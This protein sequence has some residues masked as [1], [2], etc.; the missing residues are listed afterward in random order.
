MNDIILYEDSDI[1]ICQ[2]PAGLSVQSARLGQMDLE[3][4][5]KNHLAERNPGRMPFVGVVHRLDQ[6]VEG[7][8]VFGKN[9]RATAALNR[10]LQ[11]GSLQKRYL[12]VLCGEPD[13][14]QGCLTDYL[15]KD[16]RSHT[17]AV[18]P[19][20]I[21]GGKKAVL[22]YCLLEE[23]EGLSLVEIELRTGRHHQ[24]RVQMAHRGWPLA[25][26][27]KYGNGEKTNTVALCAYKLS[28]RHPIS[29]KRM[30]FQVSPGGEIFQRFSKIL[31][32]YE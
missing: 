16:G 11:D 13:P 28:L 18:V 1:L 15:K 12:A 8:L 2:K 25:G 19:E 14:R 32:S 23:Y 30:E 29:E 4:M 26:D 10:Q 5:L 27:R 7:L 22:Q 24:I 17:S 3:S 21:S 6:P 31:S 20:H 9:S